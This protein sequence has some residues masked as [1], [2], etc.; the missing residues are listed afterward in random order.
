MIHIVN[1]KITRPVNLGS[2]QEISIKNVAELIAD[3]FDVALE[4]DISKPSGDKKRLFDIKRAKSIGFTPKIS[5][6]DGIKNTCDWYINNI[7]LIDRKFNAL[8]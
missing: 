1:N 3:Y 7:D 8:N 6:A 2:G 4:W 5:L